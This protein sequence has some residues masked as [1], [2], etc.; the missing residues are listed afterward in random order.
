MIKP[1]FEKGNNLTKDQR[2]AG[3]EFI[4]EKG[5]RSN[6]KNEFMEWTDDHVH[7]DNGPISGWPEAKVSIAL[8]NYLKGRQN[9]RALTY[10]VLTLKSFNGW[11]MNT[12]LV[13][14]RG[15]LFNYGLMWIGKSRI[16]KSAGSKTIGFSLSKYSIDKGEQQDMYVP[17]FIAYISS[18][19]RGNPS[20]SFSQEFSTVVCFRR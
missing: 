4:R 6:S 15:T 2:K 8:N 11:F 20:R 3:Y 14:M 13:K 1:K 5:P 16:G 7:D 10:W 9:A 12:V 18:F 17:S 19:S